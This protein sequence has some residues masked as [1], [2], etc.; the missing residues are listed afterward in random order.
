MLRLPAPVWQAMYEKVPDRDASRDYTEG[1]IDMSYVAS[2][3]LVYFANT[4][5]FYLEHLSAI[6]ILA[7]P[8]ADLPLGKVLSR[9]EP[10]K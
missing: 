8:P 5:R 7:E 3:G 4:L 1:E 2:E 9:V 10:S 6:R